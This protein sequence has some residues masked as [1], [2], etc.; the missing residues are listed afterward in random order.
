MIELLS[1]Q[2]LDKVARP[3]IFHRRDWSSDSSSDGLLSPTGSPGRPRWRKSRASLL[4]SRRTAYWA[5]LLFVVSLLSLWTLL[6]KRNAEPFDDGGEIPLGQSR[7]R[8]GREVFWWEQFPR[9]ATWSMRAFFTDDFQVTRL[10]SRSQDSCTPLTICSRAGAYL[11]AWSPIPL[12]CISSSCTSS[13]RCK[14][15]L[16]G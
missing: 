12:L 15:L 3:K 11:A 5:C 1:K 4:R 2:V 7:G 16:L 10:L 13:T 14:N 8:D 9:Y 6:R